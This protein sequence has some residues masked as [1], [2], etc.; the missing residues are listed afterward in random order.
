MTYV[1]GHALLCQRYGITLYRAARADESPRPSPPAQ[2]I[3][4]P[5]LNGHVQECVMWKV[6]LL[7]CASLIMVF[8]SISVSHT[9]P[10]SLLPYPTL[11]PPSPVALSRRPYLF[12]AGCFAIK[13]PWWVLPLPRSAPSAACKC[14]PHRLLFSR[15]FVSRYIFN[16]CHRVCAAIPQ[17]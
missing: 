8:P 10:P 4:F 3:L 2:D 7:Q 5:V 15:S 9:L 6:C 14:T 16:T 17:G 12:G 1:R 11:H 13:T